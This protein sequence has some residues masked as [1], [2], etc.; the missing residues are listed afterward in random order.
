MQIVNTGHMYQI[1]DDGV[2]T[3]DQLPAQIYTVNFSKM[4]G[5]YLQKFDDIE[6]TE[7]VYGVAPEKLEKVVGA[8]KCFE[9]SLGVILSGEKGIG[10]S[11]FAKMLSAKMANEGYPVLIVNTF[12]PGIAD[13]ITSIQQEVVVLFDEFDKTFYAKDGDSMNDPQ[14]SMLTLFDGLSQGKKL[15]IVTCNKLNH[16]NDYIVNRPGRFHYH[17][18]FD[19]PTKSEIEEYLRDKIDDQYFGEIEKVVAFANKVPLNYDCLRAISFELQCGSSFE[20]AIGDLNI[21]NIDNET[22][23]LIVCFKDGTKLSQEVT[24]DMFSDEQITRW[25]YLEDKRF[26]VEF[27]ALDIRYDYERGG[28]IILGKSVNFKWNDSY[29]SYEDD[30]EQEK[31]E[32]AALKENKELDFLLFRRK[33]SKNIHYA[34]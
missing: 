23:N 13:F 30:S 32:Y 6:I 21:L 9:R 22:Y 11:L 14:A 25:F 5:F 10:K 17:F 26:S 1:Y 12:I 33:S 15:F 4:T 16:L 19:Y 28:N 24:L 8:F 2:K 31:A 20:D 18:R 29:N 34:V 27:S 7:K 3:F